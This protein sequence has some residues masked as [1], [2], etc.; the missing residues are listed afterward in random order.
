MTDPCEDH[1][2]RRGPLAIQLASRAWEASRQGCLGLCVWSRWAAVTWTRHHRLVNFRML[3]AG[4]SLC[5]PSRREVGHMPSKLRM[6]PR[7][8]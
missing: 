2:P 6:E 1:L 8:F 7:L 4:I 3:A 5:P